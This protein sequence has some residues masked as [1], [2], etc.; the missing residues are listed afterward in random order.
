[1]S[2][3]YLQIDGWLFSL[4]TFFYCH[5]VFAVQLLVPIFCLVTV[6]LQWWMYFFRSYMH[7]SCMLAVS[8]VKVTCS[9]GLEH[10]GSSFSGRPGVVSSKT[11]C[12]SPLWGLST[13]WEPC[14]V[15][16]FGLELACV[17]DWNEPSLPLCPS[18]GYR[19]TCEELTISRS[20]R[21][22]SDGESRDTKEEE[23]WPSVQWNCPPL[24]PPRP[25]ILQNRNL[26]F[27]IS[28]RTTVFLSRM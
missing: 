10:T 3:R 2:H 14:N 11:V 24:L 8:S 18:D 9:A 23:R 19:K 25:P 6:P 26:I 13:S 17:P 4:Q 20:S 27:S 21:D 5:H 15:Y 16:A 22:T 12:E 1:M 28:L 7:F